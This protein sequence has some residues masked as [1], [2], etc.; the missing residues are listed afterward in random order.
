MK[1]IIFITASMLLVFVSCKKEK[2]PKI[3]E[4]TGN[5]IEQTS[6][7]YKHKLIFE[8]ETMSFFKQR[9][10]DTLTY[11]LDKKQEFIFLKLKNNP[12]VGESNHKISIN[13]KN[14]EL[15]I[16]DFFIGTSTSET[17]FK[18]E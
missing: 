16:W 17:F 15:T 2:F 5:W 11:R 12:S 8:D 13:K 6:N 4:L 18:K 14:K 7:S 3:D 9:V 10:T 1:K